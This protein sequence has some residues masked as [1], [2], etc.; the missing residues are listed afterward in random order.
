MRTTSEIRRDFDRSKSV[1]ARYSTNPTAAIEGIRS[2]NADASTVL[3]QEAA[4]ALADVHYSSK[5]IAF[6][7]EE[8]TRGPPL[9]RDAGR[10]VRARQRHDG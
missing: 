6:G 8:H 7:I 1:W 9:D 3:C 10:C 5:R 2:G 4:S